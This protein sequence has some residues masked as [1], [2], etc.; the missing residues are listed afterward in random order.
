VANFVKTLLYSKSI[1][2]SS[3][4]WGRVHEPDARQAYK[5][6]LL[7]QDCS[8]EVTQCGLVIDEEIS[9]LACSLDGLVGSHGLVEYK[10]PYKAAQLELTPLEAA[11]T[12]K[13]FFLLSMAKIS[14]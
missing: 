2:S 12:I 1:D 10:C 13:D 3:L 7:G 4:R 9:C 5:A 11:S 14:T 8:L 6:F